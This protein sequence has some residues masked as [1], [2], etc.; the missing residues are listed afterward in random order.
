MSETF[1]VDGYTIKIEQDHNPLNP[2]TE[3]DNVGKMVCWHRRYNLGDEQP[4]RS[5]DEYL[6][7][8]MWERE[9]RLHGKWVP[10][11]IKEKDLQA[12]IDKRFVV[13]PLYLYDHS[14][15]SMSTGPFGCPWDSGQVGFIYVESESKEYDDLEAGL[16]GEVKTYSQ[17]L[18]RDVWGYIIEA[19]DG[20]T[21]D[22]CWGF[23]E[24]NHC[25][26]EAERI[27]SGYPKQL[28]LCA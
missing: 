26:S 17:Y 5:P 14:G 27:V 21:L 18:Q 4:T 10:D 1:E 19:S 16:K 25:K 15:L 12:Y 20:E 7:Y 11:D 22:S 28:A 2:R 9:H 8:M 23:Y 13:L 3:Y 6:H 24:F